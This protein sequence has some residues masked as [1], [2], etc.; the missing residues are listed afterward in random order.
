M[1]ILMCNFEYPPLGGGGGI[2]MAMLAKSLAARHDVTVLTSRTPELEPETREGRVHVIR[3]PVFGRRR[4]SNASLLSL[5]AYLPSAAWRGGPLLKRERFDLVNSHFVVPTGIVGSFLARRGRVPHVIS[6]HGGDLYDPSKWMS[7]HSHALTRLAVNRLLGNA[8]L[9]IG[10]SSNT[11]DNLS[12]YYSTTTPVTRIPLGIPDR[13]MPTPDRARFG[14]SPATS[15]LVTVCRLVRRKGLEQLIQLMQRLEDL[16]CV[17]LVIGNGPQE[18][19]LQELAER[20][21]VAQKVRFLGWVSDEDK[22]TALASSDVFVSTSQHEGFGLMYLEAMSCALPVVTYDNGGQTDFLQ[23]GETG[24]LVPVNDLAAFE[25]SLRR[26]L[27]DGPVRRRVAE[28]NR[29]KF[30]ALTIEKC[31]AMYETAFET[32]LRQ[33]G[34]PQLSASQSS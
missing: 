4:S 24:G 28:T 27:G 19:A 2:A 32:V 23:D 29:H 31:A 14:L 21:G 3:V 8:D 12:R 1:K 30:D 25:A 22:F 18:A 20:L 34:S 11:L 5:A 6:V 16:D 13:P 9:V 10:Q 33:R 15:V 7:P 26:L 17:L